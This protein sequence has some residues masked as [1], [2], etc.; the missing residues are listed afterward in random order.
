[1]LCSLAALYI[2]SLNQVIYTVFLNEVTCYI[3]IITGL[4]RLHESVKCFSNT[5]MMF[6]AVSL[7]DPVLW[8]MLLEETDLAHFSPC[9]I[10][11]PL[12]FS[13]QWIRFI[14]A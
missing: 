11:L 13:S 2:N 7:L 14:W 9:F 1:M 8:S 5:A 10:F 3:A 6:C 4:L 12:L